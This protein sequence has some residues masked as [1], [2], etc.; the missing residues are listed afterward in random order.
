MVFIGARILSLCLVLFW[1]NDAFAW[2]K[3]GHRAIAILAED[4]LSPEAKEKVQ[5]LLAIESKG[6]LW[7][8]AT[9][10]DK[11]KRQNGP[12]GPMHTVRLPLDHEFYDAARHCPNGRCVVA[13]IESARSKL[14]N[15]QLNSL[16]RL[17]ALKYLV[18]FIG[19]I[20]Q[21]LHASKYLGR[22]PVSFFGQTMTLH[23]VWDAGVINHWGLSSLQI[24]RTLPK[25]MLPGLKLGGTP[26]QWAEESRDIVRD[27]IYFGV[28][29][30]AIRL[31]E[32]SNRTVVLPDNYFDRASPIIKARLVQAGLRLAEVLNEILK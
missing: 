4:R 20:H 15:T 11:M 8:I 23:E 10:A 22:E 3:T 16:E 27:Q 1:C 5:A 31:A 13:Q 25:E 24:A 26:S 21:P 32:R 28:S 29:G 18:H 14:A 9:W 6:R 2:G 12:L 19:D 7:E 17:P 30:R